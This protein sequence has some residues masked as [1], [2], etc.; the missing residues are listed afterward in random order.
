LRLKSVP[1]LILVLVSIFNPCLSWTKKSFEKKS[2][3]STPNILEDRE[4]VADDFNE[5]PPHH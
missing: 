4:R 1:T 3:K 5:D 2:P